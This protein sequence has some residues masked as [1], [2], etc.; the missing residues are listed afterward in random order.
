[1]GGGT[2]KLDPGERAR[3][4]SVDVDGVP[5]TL[6]AGTYHPDHY[7]DYREITAPILESIRVSP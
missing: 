6:I 7:D 1:L 2:Y 3:V 5:L 4:I